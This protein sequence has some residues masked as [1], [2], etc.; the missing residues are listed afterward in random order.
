MSVPKPVAPPAVPPNAVDEMSELMINDPAE[1]ER[2][3]FE[4][5]LGDGANHT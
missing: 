3:L 2:R 1:F 5:D 4:G